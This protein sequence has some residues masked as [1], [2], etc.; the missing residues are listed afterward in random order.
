MP[1]NQNRLSLEGA[2]PEGHPAGLGINLLIAGLWG[3]PREGP[4][5]W[6]F[7]RGHS[8]FLGSSYS[9]TGTGAIVF[10]TTIIVI[11][12][13]YWLT[14]VLPNNLKV[15]WQLETDSLLATPG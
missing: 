9:L 8:G 2:G 3:G 7:R 12:G 13:T 6:G 14:S 1:T 10:L 5:L 4:S 11:I 15:E